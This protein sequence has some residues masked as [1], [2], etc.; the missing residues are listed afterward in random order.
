M[1]T[2]EFIATMRAMMERARRESLT[3]DS[4]IVF[5]SDLHMGD[6]GSR[7]DF[8]HNAELM[9]ET[10][11]GRYLAEGWKLVLNGDVE[12]LHKFEPETI[13]SAY[14][15]IYG[16]F[17]SFERG[18]GLVKILGN[19]DLGLLLRDD[20]EFRLEHA[21]RLDRP[22]GALL[23]FHGHQA[24][25]LFMK[26]NYLSDF[27]VRYV[28]DPLRIKNDEFPMTSKKR[29]K[30]ERL[31]Y[32]AA[33][34]L[35]VIAVT[36]HTHRPLFESYSKYDSLRWSIES[37]LRRYASEGPD[38]RSGTAALLAVYSAEFKRLSKRERKSKV[39]RSLYEREE[40][41]SPCV[42]NSGCATARRG[43]TAIELTG[44]A[45]SLV[46][47]TTEGRAKAYVERE[48]L[49]RDRLPGTPWL[50]YTVASDSLDYIVARS[51]L[52]S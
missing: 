23:A 4:R 1:K 17:R 8:R 11:S 40:L 37:L 13:R 39:S 25:K 3:A 42:F 19:H 45:I 6:R 22:D 21:L 2:I 26:Y 46:Y 28:A 20:H 52:V 32:R 30:T 9:A 44:D 33:K 36:G 15:D 41:L 5:I 51:R 34:E 24:S 49:Y 48:A 29:F 35:G 47:W 10:L 31:V 16:L 14:G 50:R 12:E 38:E 7:D 18:G 27:V 43:Y